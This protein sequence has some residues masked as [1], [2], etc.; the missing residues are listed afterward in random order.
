MR[1]R[2]AEKG[3]LRWGSLISV[4]W[5][6]VDNWLWSWWVVVPVRMWL[7][8]VFQSFLSIL[9]WFSLDSL[10]FAELNQQMKS[11]EPRSRP[12]RAKVSLARL[13]GPRTITRAQPIRRRPHPAHAPRRDDHP[14]F[15]QQRQ[16]PPLG[17][18]SGKLFCSAVFNHTTFFGKNKREQ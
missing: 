8:V 18:A 15:S 17:R 7:V 11:V 10:L 13:R 1:D 9:T 4:A 16:W 14:E 2:E 3:F 5:V 12:T 6:L